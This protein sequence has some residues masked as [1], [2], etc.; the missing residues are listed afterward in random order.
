MYIFV[1][2]TSPNVDQFLEFFYLQTDRFVLSIMK[3]HTPI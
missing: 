3:D 1:P 2:V